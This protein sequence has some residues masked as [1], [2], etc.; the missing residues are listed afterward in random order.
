MSEVGNLLCVCVCVC[1]CDFFC[2]VWLLRKWWK[3]KENEI[4]KLCLGLGL[5][6]SGTVGERMA[7]GWGWLVVAVGGAGWWWVWWVYT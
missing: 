3:A 1:V 4:L 5:N 7:G 6:G 2:A